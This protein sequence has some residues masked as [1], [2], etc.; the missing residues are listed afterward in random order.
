VDQ[1]DDQ[2]FP[3]TLEISAEIFDTF[4]EIEWLT[5]LSA[6]G[7]GATG[8]PVR[9]VC[10]RGFNRRA[11]ARG[12][13]VPLD[14]YATNAIAQDCTFSRRGL[15]DA[16]GAPSGR[17]PMRRRPRAVG[18]AL[19]P[20]EHLRHHGA[21]R[22]RPPRR[23]KPESNQARRPVYLAERP[24]DY[25]DRLHRHLRLVRGGVA[26]AFVVRMVVS[27]SHQTAGSWRPTGGPTTDRR[28]QP[29]RRRRR[30][31]K[32]TAG[33]RR[34][35]ASTRARASGPPLL[36]RARANARF[37]ALA[38]PRFEIRS[39]TGW[40]RWTA[41]SCAST[42]GVASIESSSIT[43]TSWGRSVW[44]NAE[45]SARRSREGRVKVG[46]RR[47]VDDVIAWDR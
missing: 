9:S 19:A 40:S 38:G 15:W 30:F 3:W 42:S 14:W 27:N 37:L 25:P 5:S 26:C 12:E 24:L 4:P 34:R 10:T 45:S 20:R 23:R 41:D 35:H 46:L 1:P 32:L 18:S 31:A 43:T 8:R 21:A 22:R 13:Q 44:L 11:F 28:R 36:L 6:D 17:T 2:Y 16:L 39:K 29:R 33:R 47:L 7:P